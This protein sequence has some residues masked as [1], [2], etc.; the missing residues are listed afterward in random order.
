VSL[1]PLDKVLNDV[2]APQLL[3]DPGWRKLGFLRNPYPSRS[4]PI[5]EVFHNQIAVRDRFLR[6]LGELLRD[7][8]T[9]TLLF[10]GGNRV[11]KTHFMQHHRT[12][13]TK[14]FRERGI[15]VP[16]AVVSAQSCDLWQFYIQLVEQIDESLRFQVG[17]GLFERPIPQ[18]V[19]AHLAEL[20][21]GDFKRGVAKLA[22]Q[23]DVEGRLLLRQWIRG[24]RIRAPQRARLGVA[25]LVDGQAQML[26]TLEALVAFLLLHDGSSADTTRC[27]GVVVFVDEFELV[28]RH[29]KD[30]RDQFLQALRAFVDGCRNGVLL[31][32]GMATGISVDVLEVQSA[33]PALFARLKG[34]QDIPTLVQIGGVVEAI[35]YAKAFER[36]GREAF[37]SQATSKER[38]AVGDKPLFTSREIEV[39]YRSVSGAASGSVTQGDFFDKLHVEAENVLR[40]T[41]RKST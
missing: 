8:T 40:E 26:A 3:R 28:W 6:D 37:E 18:S 14:R 13:L 25:G 22:V 36:F 9:T 33:Y 23:D 19:S 39:F 30:R 2:V 41:L 32:V 20:P 17:A 7:K 5:W 16:I 29:R 15:A 12:E 31:C 24:E 4:H 34:A 35:E 27:G 10:T 38:Q 1:D 11:G 21:G